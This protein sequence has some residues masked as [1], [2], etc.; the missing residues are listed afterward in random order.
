MRRAGSTTREYAIEDAGGGSGR[1]LLEPV[2][3][4]AS[5]GRPGHDIATRR[6]MRLASSASTISTIEMAVNPSAKT[7]ASAS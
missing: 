6:T 2:I 5:T 4:H 1:A 7:R 3:A